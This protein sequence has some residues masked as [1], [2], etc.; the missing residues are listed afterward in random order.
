M[1]VL[2]FYATVEGHTEKIARHLAARLEK[3]G[4]RVEVAS[5]DQAGFCDPGTYEAAIMCAPIHIGRYPSSFVSFVSNWKASLQAVPDALV[6]VSLAIASEI[7]EERSEARAYPQRLIEQTG[8][9][10][11]ETFDVAGALKYTEYDFFRRWI[12]RRIAGKEG[13]PVDTSKDHELTDWAALDAFAD[14]F[15]ARVQA[16]LDAT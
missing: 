10:P 13:G 14:S 3:A 5:A 7:E 15:A 9:K 4:L 8:W 11:D 6:T 2:V 16:F 1:S 12:M